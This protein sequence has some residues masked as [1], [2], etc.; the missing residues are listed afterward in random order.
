MRSV[1]VKS[2]VVVLLSNL[3]SATD[4][5]TGTIRI[6]GLGYPKCFWLHDF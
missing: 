3:L 2:F 1:Y 6:I 4:S 5:T